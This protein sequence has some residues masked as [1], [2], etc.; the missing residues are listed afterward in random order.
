M[1]SGVP[2]VW[3]APGQNRVKWRPF[4]LKMAPLAH[5]S[6]YCIDFDETCSK[7][8]YLIDFDQF[9]N[10]GAPAR[11]APRGS[12]PPLSPPWYASGQEKRPQRRVQ[13]EV[14]VPQSQGPSRHRYVTYGLGLI[15]TA[16]LDFYGRA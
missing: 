1:G 16:G 7:H 4:P 6:V 2:R 12:C 14:P 11:P 3:C 15:S 8:S 5:K 13:G 10:F 9:L